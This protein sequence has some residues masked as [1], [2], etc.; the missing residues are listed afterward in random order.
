MIFFTAGTLLKAQ[1]HE[2]DTV[3]TVS[4]E[5]V[6]VI[7]NGELQNQLQDKPLSSVDQ[8]LEKSSK[9]NMVKRGNYAWE[10]AMNNMQ[11]ERLSLTIDGMQIFGACTDKMDPITSYADVSNLS[12]IHVNSGQQGTEN[13]A[14]IGGSIDLK[15]QKSYFDKELRSF[16]L[17][18][19]YETNAREKI[20]SS[21]YNYSGTKYFL[22]TDFIFR[23]ADNYTAGGGEEVLYS[24]FQKYNFSVVSG[25]KISPKESLV[26]SLIYDQANDVGYPALTMDVSLARALITSIS[27]EHKNDQNFINFWD[28]K[29]YYNTIEHIMDDTKRPDVPIHMDMPGWSDTFGFY[30]KGQADVKNHKLLFNWNGY[31]NRSLAEMTMYPN[32]PDEN[33]MFML[34]WPDVRTIYSG[35]YIEDQWKLKHGDQ[36]K[37]STR[38]GGQYEE[39]ADTFGYQSLTIFY[40][41]LE[42][43]QQRFLVSFNG[44]YEK[45]FNKTNIMAGLAYGQRAPSVTEAYGFYLY[46]SNDNFDY[47]GNPYLNNESSVEINFALNFD[48]HE[49]KIGAETSFFYMNHYIIGEIDPSLSPMTIGANGVKIYTGLDHATIWNSSLKA[50]YLFLTNWHLSGLLGYSLGQDDEGETLP[51]IS[52]LNYH[53]ALH[54]KKNVFDAELSLS[55]AAEQ[56]EFGAV[57]GET[58]AGSYTILN[59]NASYNFYHGDDSFYIRVGVENMFDKDYSTYADWNDIPRMGRN[60]FLNFSYVLK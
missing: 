49:F 19:G 28:T 15:L 26:A 25:Y 43:S 12:A 33:L 14:T 24:Q 11:S 52:P 32:D 45:Y 22:N 51:L 38:L 23:D 21:E 42:E 4:L 34:T 7:S 37:F 5:E 58:P 9:V 40:P 16:G 2:Q 1:E 17:D 39:I 44:S 29:I 13:G 8:H 20:I 47:I 54:Y 46:N 55:G 3:K 41:E 53:A 57:Y 60:F 35:I 36:F 10:P 56:T 27:Y 30:S 59:A 50:E 6:I 18:L 31:Y 48:L